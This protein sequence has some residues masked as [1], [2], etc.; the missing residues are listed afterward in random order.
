LGSSPPKLKRTIRRE[1][2][3]KPKFL[4]PRCKLKFDSDIIYFIHDGLAGLGYKGVVTAIGFENRR[5]GLSVV[6]LGAAMRRQ[7]FLSVLA[8]W[9]LRILH[10]LMAML[11]GS[12]PLMSRLWQW[13]TT[14]VIGGSHGMHGI[15]T[16]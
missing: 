8:T 4:K 10:W 6:D 14:M 12:L 3:L 11:G 13:W 5:L 15:S 9:K 7:I 2:S 1:L 16:G